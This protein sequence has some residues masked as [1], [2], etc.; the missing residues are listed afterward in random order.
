MLRALLEDAETDAAATAKA[1]RVRLTIHL[2]TDRE[3]DVDVRLVHSALTNL[4]RNA[5]K[6]THEGGHVE[7]RASSEGDRTVIKVEDRC[8]GLPPG[9][10]ERA[11]A[12]FVSMGPDRTGFGLGL[13]IAK[14]AADAHGG[15]IR[16]QN[17]PGKGC[18]FVLELPD[19]A[20]RLANAARPSGA[21]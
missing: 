9:A 18:I 2:E 11:F 3:L 7:V 6:F 19:A 12:P 17:L 10:V 1:K 5:V 4:V 13:A 20:P 14:Q 15:A 16:V 8:G 21:S